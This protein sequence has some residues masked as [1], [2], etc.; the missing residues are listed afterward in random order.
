MIRIGDFNLILGERKTGHVRNT[1]EHGWGFDL[2]PDRRWG[3]LGLLLGPVRGSG[4]NQTRA[5]FA[6]DGRTPF[7][8]GQK[9]GVLLL[10]L[11]SWVAFKGSLGWPLS[12]W[13]VDEYRFGESNE[14]DQGHVGVRIQQ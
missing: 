9:M 5:C 3:H 7:L 13:Q 2:H 8:Q 11:S 4:S 6:R 12:L 14:I 10:R 1:E